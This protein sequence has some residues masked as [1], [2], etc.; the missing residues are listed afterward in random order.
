MPTKEDELSLRELVPCFEDLQTMTSRP[1][2]KGG[3]R[4]F[5]SPNILDLEAY[6]NRRGAIKAVRYAEKAP[7]VR[8]ARK[9]RVG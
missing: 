5:R 9:R 4:W 7:V 2:F 1:Y 6:R 8:F 3:L